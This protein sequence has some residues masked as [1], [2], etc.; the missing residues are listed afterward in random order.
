MLE[1]GYFFL[2]GSWEVFPE[3]GPL[4]NRSLAGV[5][6]RMLT[7]DKKTREDRGSSDVSQREAENARWSGALC[8]RLPAGPVPSGRPGLVLQALDSSLVK[9]EL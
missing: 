6:A 8:T 1:K 9:S 3:P 4:R 5:Q 2:W 7:V